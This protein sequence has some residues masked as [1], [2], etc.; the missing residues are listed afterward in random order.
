MLIVVPQVGDA[1]V[2]RRGIPAD[3]RNM[4]GRPPREAGRQ[5]RSTP[6]SICDG[7]GV[8]APPV[9]ITAITYT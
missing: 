2:E 6:S 4:R 9:T 5:K 3:R 8:S 7:E 1:N